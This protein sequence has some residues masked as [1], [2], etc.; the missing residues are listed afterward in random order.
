MGIPAAS[1]RSIDLHSLHSTYPVQYDEIVR[2]GTLL[3]SGLET[4]ADFLSLCKLLIDVNELELSESLLRANTSLG[5]GEEH[6]QLNDLYERHFGKRAR[7]VLEASKVAFE[8]QFGVRLALIESKGHGIRVY[9]STGI[10]GRTGSVGTLST[11][12]AQ[13]CFVRMDLE[14][15][16][17]AY[18]EVMERLEPI[19][20]AYPVVVSV[21]LS[22]RDGAWSDEEWFLNI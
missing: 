19:D 18:A 9:R 20:P 13:E 5:Y 1:I 4:A 21:P 2:I 22:Y 12:L 15:L 8:S 11:L 7:E 17:E 10:H 3:E 6:D 16:G 14:S